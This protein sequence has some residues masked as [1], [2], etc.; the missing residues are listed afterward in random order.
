MRKDRQ[1]HG[2]QAFSATAH[3]GESQTTAIQEQ[4]AQIR[5]MGQA[6]MDHVPSDQA[7]ELEQLLDRAEELAAYEALHDEIGAATQ[8]LE[9]HRA[10]FEALMKDGVAAVDHAQRLFSEEPFVPLR[11]TAADVHRAFEAV[12]YPSRYQEE[13]TEEVIETL[14]AA[15]L[16]LADED[17]RLHLARQLLMLLPEYVSAERYLDAW[18]IQYSAFQMVEAPD[19]SNPF[20]F[21]MFNLAFA[22]WA[23]QVDSQQEALM[24]ALGIDR[25]AVAGMNVDEVEAWLQAQMADPAKKAQ[26]EAYYAAHPMMSDQ[27]EAEIIELER[28]TLSLLERDDAD[29]L[30]LS[31]EELKPWVPVLLERLASIKEQARQAAERGDWKDPGT[32]RAMGDI[33]VEIARE[34]VPVVFTPERLDQLV[35]DL[36]DYRRKL[37][38]ERETQAAMHARAAFMMLEREETPAENHLL[39]GICFASLRLLLITLSEEA[40]AKAESTTETGEVES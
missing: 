4:L 19:E 12:G 27:A 34:M 2:V 10:E 18:V 26:V 40:R 28:G 17:Q 38:D 16:H 22:E 21:T 33:F 32:L 15:V 6:V 24:H 23:S 13:P 7:Q 3:L 35:A 14:V 30:Y 11:Y 36:R 39:I 31:P 9:T 8:A 29:P 37:L 25:S 20:L 5:S 1:R